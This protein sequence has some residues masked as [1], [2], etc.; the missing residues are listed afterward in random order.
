MQIQTRKPSNT[1]CYLNPAVR[2]P[3]SLAAQSMIVHSNTTRVSISMSTHPPSEQ[4]TIS[5]LTSNVA[6]KLSSQIP[7]V[8]PKLS[9]TLFKVSQAT[10]VK[11]SSMHN[12][13]SAPSHAASPSLSYRP[14]I[15]V[16]EM[17]SDNLINHAGSRRPSLYSSSRCAMSPFLFHS[18]RTTPPL[19]TTATLSS[20]LSCRSPLEDRQLLLPPLFHMSRTMPWRTK[21]PNV[22]ANALDENAVV[23]TLVCRKHPSAMTSAATDTPGG[24]TNVSFRK[25]KPQSPCVHLKQTSISDFAKDAPSLYGTNRAVGVPLPNSAGLRKVD[26]QDAKAV[27][28]FKSNACLGGRV[29]SE[30]RRISAQS[31]ELSDINVALVA[32][33]MCRFDNGAF[34]RSPNTSNEVTMAWEPVCQKYSARPLFESYTLSHTSSNKPLDSRSILGSATIVYLENGKLSSLSHHS[35]TFESFTLGSRRT[36][37]FEERALLSLLIHYLQLF[38][39]L[40]EAPRASMPLS[41]KQVIF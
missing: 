40:S 28:R 16:H 4:P 27:W 26:K 30:S 38:L 6:R 25:G 15:K 21:T 32:A 17:S 34:F 39:L 18:R 13:F 33:T 3:R 8:D 35:R 23:S 24:P 2:F 37:L 41:S 10:E 20:K 7:A 31:E 22:P 9:K 36:I 5:R 12:V 14:A 29:L 1:C 19:S 11:P